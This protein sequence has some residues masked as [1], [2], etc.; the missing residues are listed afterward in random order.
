MGQ[1]PTWNIPTAIRASPGMV[2]QRASTQ[3]SSRPP[4]TENTGIVPVIR[5]SHSA[6]VRESTGRSGTSIT[7]LAIITIAAMAM[8][9]AMP[10]SSCAKLAVTKAQARNRVP[11]SRGCTVRRCSTTSTPVL[12]R[13]PTSSQ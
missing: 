3:R 8:M 5:S 10:T 2:T 1:P 13:K 12:T 7:V 9:R 6:A 4:T 11:D